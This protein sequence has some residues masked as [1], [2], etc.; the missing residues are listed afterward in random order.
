M[1]KWVFFLTFFWFVW[2]FKDQKVQSSEKK[3]LEANG[4]IMSHGAESQQRS[5][6]FAV[7]KKVNI[8]T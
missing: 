2:Y 6:V 5:S 1:I 3:D 7:F 4:K 8:N